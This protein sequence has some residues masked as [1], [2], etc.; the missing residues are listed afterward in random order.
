MYTRAKTHMLYGLN[1]FV[2][3]I[4]YAAFDCTCMYLCIGNQ[5]LGKQL[6]VNAFEF[7]PSKKNADSS[8]VGWYLFVC[9]PVEF[10][11]NMSKQIVSPMIP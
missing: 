1:M 7:D 6:L 5:F 3:G 9:R 4:V 8:M 11:M 2:A 10:K